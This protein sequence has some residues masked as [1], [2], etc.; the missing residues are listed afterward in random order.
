[1]N[2][3]TIFWLKPWFL[4]TWTGCASWHMLV[5]ACTA[6]VTNFRH[7]SSSHCAGREEDINGLDRG[8][9]R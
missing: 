8:W 2:Q 7:Y 6:K 4:L 5:V 1:M 9:R 3:R